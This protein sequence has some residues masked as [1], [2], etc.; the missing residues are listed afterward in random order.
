MTMRSQIFVVLLTAACASAQAPATFALT[1]SCDSE[2]PVVETLRA[3]DHVK[4]RYSF[5]GDKGTCYAVTATVANGKVDGGTVDGYLIGA[6]HPDIAAFELDVRTKAAL[7]PPP[8][9][10]PPP[11]P[12]RRRGRRP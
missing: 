6:A 12:R 5:A 10:P 4:V 7:I 3:S 9:P 2:S 1:R 11:T 8:P